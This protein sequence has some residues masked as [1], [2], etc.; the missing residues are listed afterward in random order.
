MMQS[1]TASYYL[2][3]RLAGDCRR[4]RFLPRVPQPSVDQLAALLNFGNDR[5]FMYRPDMAYLSWKNLS[6]DHDGKVSEGLVKRG[7]RIRELKRH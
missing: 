7:E 5:I 3:I 6:A 4:G 2:H 1:D